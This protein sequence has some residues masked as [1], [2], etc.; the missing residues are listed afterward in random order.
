M[1]IQVVRADT[2]EL[3]ERSKRVRRWVF[4]VE[5]EI[6]EEIE[7]DE[8]DCL[9]GGCDHFLILYTQKDVGA[10]RCMY[11]S[12]SVVRLQRF[13]ILKEVRGLGVGGEALKYVE[14]YYRKRGISRI[15]LDAKF[16]VEGFY[17]KCGYQTVSGVFEE[18]G[19]LHVKMVKD[20]KGCLSLKGHGAQV[21]KKGTMA[22]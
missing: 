22:T 14:S 3:L 4:T 8:K 16:Q 11:A 10:F 12:E 6:P 20:L 5:K 13:C 7:V 19:V 1:E 17:H 18:A 15:E 2:K 21:W 9:E